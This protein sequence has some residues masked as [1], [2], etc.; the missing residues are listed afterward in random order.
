MAKKKVEKGLYTK[1]SI[2]SLSPL[3]TGHKVLIDLF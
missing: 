3:D 1:D 2:E